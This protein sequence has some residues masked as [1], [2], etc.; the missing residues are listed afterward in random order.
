MSLTLS[1]A[2]FTPNSRIPTRYTCDGED[3]SPPLRW[4]GAPDGTRSFALVCA[5][6]DAPAGTWYHWAIYDIP[7]AA[8]QL[9]E[10][11][12]PQTKDGSH[13]ALNDFGNRGYGGPCP[14]PRHGAH[15]YKF[16][17]YALK[18]DSLK[19]SGAPRCRDVER[20]AKANALAQAETVGLYER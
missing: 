7:A 17:L 10:D 6:P 12:P 8:T 15:H 20:A 4:A 14:P 2:A 16:T 5:D 9:A 18:V 19:L 13:Q 11:C 3:I 1:S